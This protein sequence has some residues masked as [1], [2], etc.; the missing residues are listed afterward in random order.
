MSDATLIAKPGPMRALWG[1]VMFLRRRPWMVAGS[2]GLLLVNITIE[3]SLPQFLGN[4]ITQLGKPDAVPGSFSLAG[5]VATFAGLV[6]LRAVIGLFLGPLRNTTAQRTLGDIRAAVYDALQ[7]QTFSWHDNA[8]TGELISRA[9]T[10]VFRLQ[11]FMF[12]CLLFSVDV[13]AGLVGTL[14]FLFALSATLGW[15]A[16]AAMVPTVGAMAFFAAKLQPRWRKVHEQHSAMSTVIQENI[17]GVRVVKAFARDSAE[18]AKFRGKRDAFLTELFGAVNYWAARVPFA[19]FLFGLGVP[20]VLW[21]GGR[22]VIA[23]EMP[24]GD[25]AKAVFYLLALGGRIGVIGQVTNIIQNA[26]SAAQ[27]VH[28]ILH[29]PGGPQRSAAV[30]AASANQGRE[31]SQTSASNS[32]GRR[33]ACATFS[34]SVRFENVSFTYPHEPSLRVENEDKAPPK[35][36]EAPKSTRRLALDDA[37]FEVAPGHTVALVGPTGAGKSTLLA[38]IPRFYD[39]TAGRVL[40]DGVDVRELDVAA[41]RRRIGIVFQETFLFSASIADNI[42]FGRT[43][44]SREDIIRVAKAARAHDFISELAQGYD[45]IIG[46]RGI[47]LSG[48]QRQR[49]AIAR[50]LLCDP[51]IILLDDATSAIDPKTEREIRDATAELCRGRTTFIV[52][53]RASTVRNADV[54][55]V[56]KEGRLVERGT[57]AELLANGGVY[58]DLFATQLTDTER[59]MG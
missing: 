52:A 54:I 11:D 47:S 25:L 51:Q 48:G 33:D 55:L 39:P 15:L 37:S 1:V 19:Q 57:H 45:S 23:G 30:S 8:R 41:L 26:S 12:V 50:A 35:P 44:A 21:A 34:S 42:A 22:H 6:T 24:L 10:D 49:L 20:L 9:S 28:E 17:A 32:E 4:A 31:A 16:V 46:E 29:A 13:T 38:L 14:A 36:P 5:L 3:L 43:D 7:R 18:V 53:Q 56:L 40:V 2:V 59:S 27:R 58:H